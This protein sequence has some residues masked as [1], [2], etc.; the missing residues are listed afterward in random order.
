MS[1]S[2]KQ[3][4]LMSCV[5]RLTRALSRWL[6]RAMAMVEVSAMR[7]NEDGQNLIT[8]MSAAISVFKYQSLYER[9]V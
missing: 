7:G 4:G 9:G 5:A 6:P 1:L 3:G 8:K 2:F